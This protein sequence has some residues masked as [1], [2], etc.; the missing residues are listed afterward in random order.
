MPYIL[1]APIILHPF[2]I[3]GVKELLPLL[4]ALWNWRNLRSKATQAALRTII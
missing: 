1:L 4:L 2:R 3:R